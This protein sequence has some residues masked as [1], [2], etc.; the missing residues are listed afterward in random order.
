MVGPVW[1]IQHQIDWLDRSVPYLFRVGVL[2][3]AVV[4]GVVSFTLIAWWG[5]KSEFSTLLRMLSDRL[6]RRLP[7][8]LQ[9][10]K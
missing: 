9:A 7:Q 8:F 3:S 2:V 5:G 10:S 6:L 4:A 1:W